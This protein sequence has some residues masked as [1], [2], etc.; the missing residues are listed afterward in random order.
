[1]LIPVVYWSGSGNTEKMAECIAEAINANGAEA[2]LLQVSQANAEQIA[3]YDNIALGCPAMGAEQLEECEFEP[4]MAELEGKLEGKRVALFGSYGWGG[5]YMDEWRARCE[6]AGA[7][8]V[9]TPVLA[10]NE[11]D[12]EALSACNELGKLLAE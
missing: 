5:S 1:M 2:Q 12:D 10:L 11:P 8:V 9:G 6:A 7:V 4:F 3:A